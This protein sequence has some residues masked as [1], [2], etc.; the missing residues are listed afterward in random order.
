MSGDFFGELHKNSCVTISRY[1]FWS[2]VK[3]PANTHSRKTFFKKIALAA[4]GMGLISGSTL[5]AQDER[6]G[7]K[8]TKLPVKVKRARNIVP[9]ADSRG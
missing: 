3:N 9:A 8:G 7:A 2:E 6:S 4:G 5:A 1:P